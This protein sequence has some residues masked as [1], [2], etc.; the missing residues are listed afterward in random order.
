VAVPAKEMLMEPPFSVR[1]LH[2]MIGLLVCFQQLLARSC[3]SGLLTVA[4][5]VEGVGA[6]VG[7]GPGS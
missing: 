6:E 3:S 2:E 5:A 1:M 4:A 7:I